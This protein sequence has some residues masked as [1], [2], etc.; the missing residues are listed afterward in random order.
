MTKVEVLINNKPI[1]ESLVKSV[2]VRSD[3]DTATLTANLEILQN[4]YKGIDYQSDIIYSGYED[5]ITSYDFVT[6]LFNDVVIFTGYMSRLN[7]SFNKGSYNVAQVELKSKA[8]DF[9]ESSIRGKRSF[10]KD[11]T[12]Y[13]LIKQMLTL[14]NFKIIENNFALS[15]DDEMGLLSG[16][17]GVA[18]GVTLRSPWDRAGDQLGV[19]LGSFRGGF[20]VAVPADLTMT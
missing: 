14:N 17:F 5:I 15:Q 13:N 4:N 6:I 9:Y 7:T 12:L 19:T 10:Q 11:V 20:R 3:I 8:Q 2:E 16:Y 18:F 1:Q